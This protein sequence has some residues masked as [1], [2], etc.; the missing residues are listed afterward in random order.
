MNLLNSSTNG[1]IVE[2]HLRKLGMPTK[3]ERGIVTLIGKYTVCEKGNV[4]TP[5]QA[6]ILK[7]VGRPMA[8]FKILIE[9]CFTKEDGFE[10]IKKDK[11]VKGSK[12][13]PMKAK[14]KKKLTKKSKKNAGEDDTAM[15]E[16]VEGSDSEDDD[17][18]DDSD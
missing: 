7:L 9:C 12:K 4:L 8:N 1:L 6:K 2:P 11:T 10:I 3:L 5:E 18:M 16:I 13:I 17:E 14:D 15:M